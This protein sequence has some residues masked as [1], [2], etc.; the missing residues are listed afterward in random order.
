MPTSRAMRSQLRDAVEA[1]RSSVAGDE[2]DDDRRAGERQPARRH[3][4]VA[5]VVAG[6]AQ[7]DDRPGPPS[8]EVDGKR[9]DR[10]RDGGAGVLHEPLLGDARGPGLAGRPR[11]SSRLR[12]PAA[13][14]DPPNA[15]AGR[16]GPSRRSTDRRPAAAERRRGSRDGRGRASPS[17]GSRRRPV[18]RVLPANGHEGVRHHRRARRGRRRPMPSRRPRQLGRRC[19]PIGPSS[20]T[21]RPLGA[22][23]RRSTIRPRSQREVV[24]NGA[25]ASRAT[26]AESGATRTGGAAAY[27]HHGRAGHAAQRGLARPAEG[28]ADVHQRVGPRP[29]R[30]RATTSSARRLHRGADNAPPSPTTIRP[31]TRRTLVSTAPTGIPKASAATA[32]AVY[33]PTPGSDSSARRSD[34]T[35]PPCSSTISR[36]ARYRLRARRS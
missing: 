30:S 3:E 26:T 16:A 14:P 36:A 25:G 29:G 5:A 13:R 22:A 24:E 12:W 4:P 9:P 31:S 27:R 15:C 28:R 20:A 23:R 18:R 17:K 10:R 8:L 2:R 32:R 19:S 1:S 7:D 33:G 35:R 34:G 11:S 6:A 21:H